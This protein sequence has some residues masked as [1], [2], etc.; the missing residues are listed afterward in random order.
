MKIFGFRLARSLLHR[1]SEKNLPT[2]FPVH[3][4]RSHG[5]KT[6]TDQKKDLVHRAERPHAQDQTVSENG[7][8]LS[9]DL[10][11]ETSD[12]FLKN[13]LS[14]FVNETQKEPAQLN[15]FSGDFEFLVKK[16]FIRD[17]GMSLAS[18]LGD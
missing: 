15:N 6:T 5:V 18:Y 1:K 13:F 10:E 9:E 8:G 12:I 3:D 11:N 2:I 16:F 7:R 17:H 4:T 14:E